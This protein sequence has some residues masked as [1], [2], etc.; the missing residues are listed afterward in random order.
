MSPER[1]HTILALAL[2]IIGGMTSQNI[3]NLIDTAMVGVLG[4]NALAAVGI[5]GFANFMCIALILG[6]SA[7]VQAI[8]S[9]RKGEGNEDIMAWSLNGG[10]FLALVVGLPLSILM[11]WLAPYF[12]PY[13][14]ADPAVHPLGADYLQMRLIGMVA[15]GM[16]FAFRGYWNGVSMSKLYLRTLLIMHVVNVAL[17]YLLIFGKFGFPEMGVMGAGLGT[18]I[19]LF[20]GTAVYFFLGFR[21]A[22]D[23]GFMHGLPTKDVLSSMIR[24]SLPSSI[25]QF[26]F[27][28]GLTAMFW[29]IGRTGTLEL[30]AGSVLVNIMLVAILPGIGFGLAAASLA[31][32][33]LGRGDVADAK[34]WGWDV[35]KMGFVILFCLGLPMLLFPDFLLSAFLHDQETLDLARLPL[36]LVGVF[37]AFDGIGM[38]LMNCLA[39]VGASKSVMQVSL[40]MQWLVFMPIA[41]LVGP[42]LGGGLLAVWL[43]Q[44]GYRAIQAG[45]FAYLWHGERWQSIKV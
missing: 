43:A 42:V 18:T 1:R 16:N 24:I 36:R 15:V 25:Q 6:L 34:Q 12:F 27:A 22:K 21:H 31:G 14:V 35:S 11:Y 20:V 3:L 7:G 38:I 32:Q 4:P 23:N 9:R 8:A 40:V 13:L 37:I 5:G 30:A 29:I 17:N 10:L 26:F 45:I 41:W 39:G 28:A 2:P 19:S 44:F 33:A